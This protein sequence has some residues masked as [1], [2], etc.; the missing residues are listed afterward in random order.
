MN[1]K[2]DLMKFVIHKLFSNTVT[3][4]WKSHFVKNQR[5][6]SRWQFYI[7]NPPLSYTKQMFSNSHQVRD[8]EWEFICT[9]T[10]VLSV[11]I[12][13]ILSGWIFVHF[14]GQRDSTECLFRIWRVNVDLC[15]MCFGCRWGITSIIRIHINWG[16]VMRRN[17]WWSRAD[18]R[19]D[20]RRIVCATSH[21]F[22]L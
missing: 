14:H 2:E 6:H 5:R 12:N 16:W 9:G 13:D 17:R 10:N 18:H 22:T 20:R 21:R 15:L 7:L 8:T 3:F 4:S 11:K 1:K 19:A